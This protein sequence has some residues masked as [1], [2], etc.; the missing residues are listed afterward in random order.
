MVKILSMTQSRLFL[1]I[2]TLR[3]LRIRQIFYQLWYRVSSVQLRS[4]VAPRIRK[5]ISFESLPDKTDSY[6]PPAHFDFLNHSVNFPTTIEWNSATEAK[7]WLY[8]LHYFDWL[9]SASMRKNEENALDTIRNWV[10]ENPP[11]RG[12]GWEPYPLSLR[13]VNWIKFFSSTGTQQEDLMDSLANQIRWLDKRLEYHLLANHLWANAKAL[14][15]AGFYFGGPEGDQW[16][17]K[18]LSILS[19]ELQE[20][21]TDEGAHFERT[22][23]YHAIV[24]EDLLD[25]IHFGS[26]GTVA[27]SD[28]IENWKQ[29]A[30]LMLTHLNFLLHPDGELAFFNDTTMG[31]ALPASSLIRYAEQLGVRVEQYNQ[32]NNGSKINVDD[33]PCIG[34][35]RIQS[36][37]ATVFFDTGNIAPSYQPGHAHAESGCFELSL[38]SGRVFVNAGI[39]TYEVSDLRHRQRST[40]AHNAVEIDGRNSSEVWAGFRVAKRATVSNRAIYINSDFAS[41]AVNHDGYSSFFRSI[42]LKRNIELS[43]HHLKITDAINGPFKTAVAHYLLHPSASIEVYESKVEGELSLAKGLKLSFRI[44]GATA[45]VQEARWY[46]GFG[47][48]CVTKKLTLAFTSSQCSLTLDL[49]KFDESQDIH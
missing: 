38:G 16:L 2:S 12:N 15:F 45:N 49:V 1:L 29:R 21:F 31:I 24:F 22:P 14:V 42:E 39:S 9:Q 48:E 37:K 34:F 11:G 41:V 13:I 33:K 20:Q 3:F 35:T 43:N 17:D 36:S 44:E 5:N 47:L 6:T 32:P 23:M 26:Y 10:T 7:L 28:L 46:P 40:S 18:G 4:A 8:N 30:S 25:L 27:D 19:S